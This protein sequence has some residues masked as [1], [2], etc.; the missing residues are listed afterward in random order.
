MPSRVAQRFAWIVLSLT[1]LGTLAAYPSLPPVLAT[2]FAAD[3]SPNGT[4]DAFIGAFIIPVVMLLVLMLF[5]AIPKI[6]PLRVNIQYFRR[7]F[8]EFCAFLMLFFAC[9]QAAVIIWN[10]GYMFDQMYVVLPAAGALIFY[11]GMLL[12]QTRRNWFFGIR[13][14]WTI[15]SDHVWQKTHELA[16][17][18]FKILGVII[19]L[20]VLAPSYAL[21]VIFLPLIIVAFG[22]VLYSYVVYEQDKKA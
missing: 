3:G 18:L 4:A 10:L 11:L 20:G 22:L 1:W 8:D 12:P 15:S 21:W 7:Q 17:T 14:P 5:T 19:V 2:H 13:T 6:D 16:G 9:I